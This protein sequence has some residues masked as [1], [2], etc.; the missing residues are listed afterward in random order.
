MIYIFKS[1]HQ[2]MREL[3]NTETCIFKILSTLAVRPARGS[4][5]AAPLC[6]VWKELVWTPKGK[7]EGNHAG[8]A[9]SAPMKS[10]RVCRICRNISPLF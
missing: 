5:G 1:T 10:A 8:K 2:Q 9:R 7:E 3:V 4:R 6:P